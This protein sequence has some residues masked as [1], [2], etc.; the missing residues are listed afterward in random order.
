MP[1][2]P[3]GGRNDLVVAKNGSSWQ[4]PQL[5]MIST[6]LRAPQ[7]SQRSRSRA[8]RQWVARQYGA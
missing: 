2:A 7:E 6:A 8:A 1:P 5:R 3:T 4:A